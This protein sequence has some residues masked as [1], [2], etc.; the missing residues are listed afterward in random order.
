MAYQFTEGT[1]LGTQVVPE[2]A[3]VKIPP[4]EFNAQVAASLLPSADD[5]MQVQ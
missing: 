5:A 4:P 1:A 2:S 3:E